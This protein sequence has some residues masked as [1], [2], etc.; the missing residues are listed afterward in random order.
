MREGLQNSDKLSALL[1]SMA[2]FLYGGSLTLKLGDQF[3][4]F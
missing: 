4:L 1:P 2:N 3:E